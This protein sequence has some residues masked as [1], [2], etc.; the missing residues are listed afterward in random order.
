MRVCVFCGSR[1]GD[2]PIHAD[3]ARRFGRLIASQGHGLVYGGGNIGLMGVIADSALEQGG[4]VIGVIPQHL[5]EREVAHQGLSQLHVVDSMHTR[6]ALMADLADFFVAAPGGFGTLDELC[7]ILTW[8]QLGLHRKPCGLLNIAGYFDPLLAM[9]DRATHEGFLS[10]SHRQLIVSDDDPSRLL[11]RL[12]A[13]RIS[14]V[15]AHEA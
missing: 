2:A 4:E 5:L 12:A 10:Q 3:T 9:F 6:K 11:E 14:G 8:A 13:G 1:T 7:E 15:N